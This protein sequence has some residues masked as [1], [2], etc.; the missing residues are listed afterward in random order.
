M[1]S[2][3]RL[4]SSR[5]GQPSGVQPST[6]SSSTATTTTKPA[7][8]SLGKKLVSAVGKAAKKIKSLGKKK[9]AAKP[10]PP[11]TNQPLRRRRAGPN[12][13]GLNPTTPRTPSP[14]RLRSCVD[15]IYTDPTSPFPFRSSSLPPGTTDP[16][17]SPGSP[18]RGAFS[19][20]RLDATAGQEEETVYTPTHRPSRGIPRSV[21]REEEV[22]EEEEVE[23]EEEE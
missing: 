17:S 4:R 14:R 3:G 1:F 15:K 20:A 16:F 19:R 7:R 23:E 5:R 18:A 21:L 9:Q 2:F 8:V 13:L 11:P 12:P 22:K 6:T 10:P